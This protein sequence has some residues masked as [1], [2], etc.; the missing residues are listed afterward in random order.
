MCIIGVLPEFTAVIVPEIRIIAFE[1]PLLSFALAATGDQPIVDT[2]GVPRSDKKIIECILQNED[3][4]PLLSAAL[5]EFKDGLNN[6]RIRKGNTGTDH[7]GG[8]VEWGAETPDG[9]IWFPGWITIT[10]D[11][12]EIQLIA[13]A[14][15]A[16][17]AHVLAETILHEIAHP[18]IG[19]NGGGNHELDGLQAG[20]YGFYNHI[21]GQWVSEAYNAI[22]DQEPNDNEDAIPP[23]KRR[24]LPASFPVE[25]NLRCLPNIIS[26]ESRLFTS[27]QSAR[28]ALDALPNYNVT[29]EAGPNP[30]Y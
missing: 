19:N 6:I 23:G 21:L 25:T 7:L 5:Q 26:T 8:I 4:S 11:P 17:Y 30:D 20:D 15:N 24:H 28:A 18:A 16:P 29:Y 13:K 10:Y 27:L 9:S 14:W 12:M 1:I 22:F 3:L 2:T